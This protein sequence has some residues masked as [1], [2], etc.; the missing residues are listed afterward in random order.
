M[1]AEIEQVVGFWAPEPQRTG[2]QN[3]NTKRTPT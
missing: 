1:M 2:Y 3:V